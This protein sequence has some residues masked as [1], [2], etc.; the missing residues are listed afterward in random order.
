MQRQQIGLVRIY[1]MEIKYQVSS[2]SKFGCENLLGSIFSVFIPQPDHLIQELVCL[3]VINF[4]VYYLRNFIF[5]F[6]INYYWSRSQLYSFRERVGHNRFKHKHMENWM[7]RAYRLWET[8]NE[9][10]CTRLENDF[11]GSKIFFGELF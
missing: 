6:S 7:D 8:E 3:S 5:R 10:Q 1:N 2:M 11:V 9:Q 4:G